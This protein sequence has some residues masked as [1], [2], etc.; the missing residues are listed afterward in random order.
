MCFNAIT[1]FAGCCQFYFRVGAKKPY[2]ISFCC[3][4]QRGSTALMFA[5]SNGH[6]EVVKLLLQAKANRDMRDEVR[7]LCRV[8]FQGFQM[9]RFLLLWTCSVHTVMALCGC[10]HIVFMLVRVFYF[11][12]RVTE[13][14]CVFS[15]FPLHFYSRAGQP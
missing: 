1:A 13:A 4:L 3:I 15:T 5:A 2:L 6:R 11:E 9:L 12:L 7:Y 10:K 8:C 14:V